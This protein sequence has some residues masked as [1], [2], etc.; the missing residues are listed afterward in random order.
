MYDNIRKIINE[1]DNIVCL[2]GSGMLKESGHPD[3]RDDNESYDIE[4]KYGYSPEELFSATFYN[5]RSEMF[6]EYYRTHILHLSGK[7]SEAYY[8]VAELEKMGKLQGAITKGI[9]GLL[10]RAGCTKVVNLHGTILKNHC[11]RCKQAYSAEYM[12][13]SRKIPSCEKCNTP[14]RPGVVLFG[15]MVNNQDITAAGELVTNADVVMLLGADMT[16]CIAEHCLQ[17]YKGNKLILIKEEEHYADQMADYIVYGKIKEV[18][19][20]LI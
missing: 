11:P 18:L 5:T 10:E 20:K 14:I 6:Y 2:C 1:S 8:A 17:Y 4:Q 15:E 9:Y 7:P 3:Y 19:P 16:A 13:N 12:K